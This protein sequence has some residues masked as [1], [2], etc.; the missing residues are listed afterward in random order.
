VKAAIV[1]C[2]LTYLSLFVT[3]HYECLKLGL[4]GQPADELPRAAGAFRR[5]VHVIVPLAL[6]FV[7]VLS[8]Y[9]VMNAALVSILCI[10]GLSLFKREHRFNIAR[11]YQALRDGAYTML[12]VAC[13]CACAGIV[14]G[15]I[16]L[17]GLGL[18]FASFVI[19]LSQ[20]NVHLVLVLTMI[21]V[22]ILGMGLPA[23]A[24]YL[25]GV[26]VAGPALTRVGIAPLPA[27]LFIFYFAAI[28]SITPPIA[29]A[30]YVGAGIA[31][32]NPLKTGFTA[33][34]L[35]LVSFVIPYM[36][37]QHAGLLLEGTVAHIVAACIPAAIGV[38]YM[39]IGITGFLFIRMRWYERL[40]LLIAGVMAVYPELT[41][42]L[43][44]IAVG[45]ALIFFQYLQ[46]RKRAI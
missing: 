46:M 43:V 22:L 27:H 40:T 5:G 9:P 2:V 7:L 29:L 16:N 39:G 3:T 11:L 6:L 12:E 8:N 13:A 42:D 1:P 38:V 31:G 10:I 18:K 37:V 26:S 19:G 45:A 28:S 21:V 33:C 32:S 17:S 4:K 25:I 20:G 41:T 24:S 30:A 23:T 15:V 35:G 14:I 36:F 34:W 44:G